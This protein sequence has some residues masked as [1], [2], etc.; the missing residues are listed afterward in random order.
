MCII[1]NKDHLD[2]QKFNRQRGRMSGQLRIR[3]RHR[4]FIGDWFDYLMVSKEEMKKILEGT[5]WRIRRFISAKNDAQYI[6]VITK[7]S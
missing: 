4:K 1:Q 7:E 6:A 5:G 3:I 2:Y